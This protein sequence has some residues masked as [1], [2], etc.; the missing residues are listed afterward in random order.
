MSLLEC[1]I[2]IAFGLGGIL[3]SLFGENF[4]RTDILTGRV[5][6]GPSARWSGKL[7]FGVVG[8]AFLV[9]GFYELYHP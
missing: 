8:T 4:R 7:L 9:F 3:V 1:Y 6:Y 2:F 5:D